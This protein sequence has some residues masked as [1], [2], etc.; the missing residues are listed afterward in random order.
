MAAPQTPPQGNWEN[1]GAAP[2]E[3][4]EIAAPQ[5]P[6]QGFFPCAACPCP[7]SPARYGSPARGDWS[8]LGASERARARAPCRAG[9][10]ARLQQRSL[11]SNSVFAPRPGPHP[12][13]AP[14]TQMIRLA[15][16]RSLAFQRLSRDTPRLIFRVW[17]A[18]TRFCLPNSG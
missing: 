4:W 7:V 18:A 9:A 11:W 17:L 13:C 6:P 12:A 15:S 3:N 2:G 5:A 10:A 16:G 8:N 1:G 14:G